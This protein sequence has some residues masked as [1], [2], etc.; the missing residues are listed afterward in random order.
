MAY[1]EGEVP[2]VSAGNNGGFGG[3]GGEGFW[4]IVLLAI[5]FGGNGNG[6]FGNGRGSGQV[7][8]FNLATDFATLERKLDGVNSGI[9]DGFYAMNTGMLNGFAGV[10]QSVT[11]NGYETR[12]A[13]SDLGYALKDC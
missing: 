6:I 7:G 10:T 9:C 8:D 1:F 12:H 3:F 13:I 11:T 4:A 2:V 5:I